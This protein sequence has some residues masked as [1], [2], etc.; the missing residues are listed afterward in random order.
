MRAS[1]QLVDF[2]F[3]PVALG[4]EAGQATLN[5]PETKPGK[6]GAMA[7][8]MERTDILV[9]SFSSVDTMDVPV[10]RMDD[11][12]ADYSGQF[13]LKIDTEGFETAVL[14][15]GPDTLKRCDFVVL[16]L[17][18]TQRFDLSLIHI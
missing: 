17:S 5:I 7:S 12:L 13:G 14:Q 18:V 8:L 4:A 6:G 3:H 15:G 11:L 2:D 10:M 16:E 1:G 9:D